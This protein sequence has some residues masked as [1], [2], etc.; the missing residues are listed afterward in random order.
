MS[1]V[2]I[3]IP[4]FNQL[5]YTRQCLESVWSTTAGHDLEVIVFDNGSTDGTLEYLRSAQASQPALVVQ[6]SD[7]NLGYSPAN[8]QAA[9]IARGDRLVLLNNDTIT[10]P[11]WLSA[12]LAPLEHA[13]VG[14]VGA[15]LIYPGREIINHAGYVYS[16]RL[17]SFYLL[18]EGVRRDFPAA[19]KTRQFQAVLG[20]CVALRRADFNAVGGLSDFGLE[21]VD[22]CLKL[23]NRG[24]MVQYHPAATLYHYG[25]MTIRNSPTGSIPV[26]SSREFQEHWPPSRLESDDLRYYQEDGVV[27]HY[28]SSGRIVAVSGEPQFQSLLG[29]ISQ[30]TLSP[31]Y[32]TPGNCRVIVEGC[33]GNPLVLMELLQILVECRAAEGAALFCMHWHMYMPSLPEPLLYG[34]KLLEKLGHHEQARDLA[35]RGLGMG[36][37]SDEERNEF[38]SIGRF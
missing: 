36:Y 10:T 38:R 24:L 19:Q 7:K 27:P 34:A 37:L 21:D 15:R 22:L 16:S 32:L 12:L 20:A 18:Y 17:N 2:S 13:A 5:H 3:I 25:Q 9:E 1:F 23:R 26:H 11:G 8:N 29:A 33:F 31:E 35:A 30:R 6:H 4:V 28:T 14:I